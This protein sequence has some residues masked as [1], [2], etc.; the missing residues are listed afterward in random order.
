VSDI[1][2][3]RVFPRRTE[4]T[5]IDELVFTTEPPRIGLPEISE[6]HVSVAFTY[7]LPRAEWL[8]HQWGAVG[9]QVKMGG[10]ACDDHGGE[11]VPGRYIKRGYCMTSRG[12]NNHCWFCKVPEREGPLRELPITEGHNVLDSNLLQASEG[13]IRSVFSM[14]ARQPKRA[15]F[16]GGLEAKIMKPWHCEELRKLNPERLYCAYDTPDDY[17]PLVCAG[18]MLQDVG[19]K[20]SNHQLACYCL[21]GYKGDTFDKAEKRLN[22]TIKAG[23]MPYA[24]LYRDEK[25]QVN[26]DW[27]VFQREWLRPMIVA[28][29]MKEGEHDAE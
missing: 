13:H 11:F 16:T 17:E 10:P 3:A 29:K 24:M 20:P 4:A 6:V 18:R 9:V 27:K 25:G 8:A 19:F 2:I 14:L 22:D 12:C 7:D 26:H 15:K 5:P 21:V 23:F 1:N 28:T